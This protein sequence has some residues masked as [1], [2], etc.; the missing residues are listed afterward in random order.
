MV[1]TPSAEYLILDIETV[2][3]TTAVATYRTSY[4]FATID[5]REFTLSA[6]LNYAFSPDLTLETF[7][8]P[9]AASGSF[10][11]L[12]RLVAPRSARTEG[13]AGDPSAYDFNERS[14]RT[15]AVLRWE[16][17]PGSL[18]YAVWQRSGRRSIERHHP[19]DPTDAFSAFG[20][21]YINF[22]ALKM[23]LWVPL[24]G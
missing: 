23:S 24:G 14:L 19:V 20:G 15:N 8:E 17:R 21:R 7:A 11:G 3:D 13:I 10:S 6:R 4:R 9:Y 12:G 1:R 2:P 18:F 22:F 16:W 5:F